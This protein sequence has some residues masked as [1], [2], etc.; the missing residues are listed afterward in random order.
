MR[1]SP[2]GGQHNSAAGAAMPPMAD[3]LISVGLSALM[4]ILQAQG[5]AEDILPVLS[6]AD[7]LDIG[8]NV[9]DRRRL[10][11]AL[12]AWQRTAG[13]VPGMPAGQT[14]VA[15][16]RRPPDAAMA[17]KPGAVTPRASGDLRQ[18]TI[19][20]CDLVDATGW[21]ERLP[22][23]TWHQVVLRYQHVV[24][25][26]VQ[27]WGGRIA[28][29]LGDGVLVYFG[30]PQAL[31]DAALRAT[32]AACA[33]REA[34]G[35]IDLQPLLAS[36]GSNW[37]ALR[38]RIG[39]DTGRVV[40]GDVGAGPHREHLALGDTPHIAARLQALA[41]PGAV[42]ISEATRRLTAG[43][44]LQHDLGLHALK[45]VRRPR[46]VWQ[47]QGPA[48][49]PS[50]FE[51]R[52][53]GAA[54]APLVG[55]SEA[56]AQLA[57]AWSQVRQGE[58]RVLLL[59]GEAGVGKSRLVSAWAAQACV[60]PVLLQCTAPRSH[61]AFHPLVDGLQR[62]LS[63]GD[64]TP[65]PA[66]W[67]ALRRLVGEDARLNADQIRSLGELL[68][69]PPEVGMPG[70]SMAHE[71]E[72]E[73]ARALVDWLLAA[74]RR[75]P[76]VIWL[77]DIHWADPA[78]L[79]WLQLLT[80]AIGSRSVMLVCTLR[81]DLAL[82]WPDSPQLRG[83][84]LDGLAPQES[85]ELVNAVVAGER[86]R[87][88]SMTV[89]WSP[90]WTQAVV[91]RTDGIPLFVEELTRAWLEALASTQ[92][93]QPSAALPE[94]TELSA[95]PGLGEQ[96]L[97][98][99]LRDSLTARLDRH[100]DARV[101]AQV[102]AVLGREFELRTLRAV[103]G[104]PDEVWP[105]ALDALQAI[106]LALPL[107]LPGVEP[108]R[109]AFKHAL[110]QDTAYDTL[111][112]EHRQAL[113]A[114]ALRVLGGLP[115]P[116]HELAR[117]ACGAGLI[118]LA[119]GHWCSAGERALSRLAL[120]EAR[121]HMHGALQ[122]LQRLPDGPERDAL[123]LPAQAKLGAVHM[124]AQGWAAKEVA[125]AFARARDLADRTDAR[126]GLSWPL[127]GMTVY[128]MVRG[129][130]HQ[131]RL[132]G[133]RLQ[134]VARQGGQRRA[135]LVSDIVQVQ[136]SYYGGDWDAVAAW[137]QRVEDHY[138]D[139]QDRE[140]IPF[141]TTDLLL[142]SRVHALHVR[143]MRRSCG[144]EAALLDSLQR[145][146]RQAQGL[147]HAYSLAWMRS[148]GAMACLHAGDA[149]SLQPWAESSLAMARQH[150]FAYVAAM[151][152]FQLGWCEA[153]LHDPK[154]GLARMQRGLA[155]FKQTGA[156]IVRPCFLTL[157]AHTAMK[158]GASGAS[159]MPWLQR[160]QEL[161]A[162]GGETWYAAETFRVLAMACADPASPDPQQARWAL[163]QAEACARAQQ[164]SRW[165]LAIEATRA[166]PATVFRR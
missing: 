130:I 159:V 145:L 68:G 150:G 153:E 28:Q 73:Q 152:E 13:L 12:D 106:G 35:V 43:H 40:V 155:A 24:A 125:A 166:E 10:R 138:Q 97:P 6:D 65:R 69:W 36:E 3:W 86:A 109:W 124:L 17:P 9:G 1:L 162:Q 149:H 87:A 148:W 31:E 56:L 80:Q 122:A 71:R 93:S 94:P 158:A 67:P 50:R 7:L 51:A 18:L 25:E 20:F 133:D 32:H 118:A 156:G 161:M 74:S 88:V 112:A 83:I 164:A 144:S 4:P 98:L 34:V 137:H 92:A 45:G 84:R 123:E 142:V 11:Q 135:H 75:A 38:V 136:L 63:E 52:V 141:Y 91:A 62:K 110:V 121:A 19:L 114:A 8:L 82:N 22:P 163:D 119:V 100:P 134:A 27:H 143:C 108:A 29:Y 48:A 113:H 102:G 78:T 157:Q 70:A 96:R 128:D 81:P 127:W 99:T 104:L 55:R 49:A 42:L 79:S 60:R 14:V 59:S 46:Q 154:A 57:D 64:P 139:P 103:A 147:G 16:T 90:A 33:M 30:H 151:A 126:E 5:V 21:C 95:L 2:R 116:P 89:P 115:T 101:L 107:T 76:A 132:T 66:D 77:E 26:V 131:A 41:E 58:G 111:T 165:L 61:V 140:L 146:D 117:H 44:F 15:L 105:Q 39:V 37:P 23:E 54:Q 160:A 85:T 72:Q 120:G 129:D 47:V 53:A